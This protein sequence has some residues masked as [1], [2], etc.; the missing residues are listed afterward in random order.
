MA[1]CRGQRIGWSIGCGIAAAD[2]TELQ[3]LMGITHKAVC[4]ERLGKFLL[5]KHK[6]LTGEHIVGT[7]LR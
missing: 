2:V 4:P 1:G 6:D 5:G 7:K 3:R